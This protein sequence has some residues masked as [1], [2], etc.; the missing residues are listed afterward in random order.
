MAETFAPIMSVKGY[1][2]KYGV[3]AIGRKKESK[4]LV[5]AQILDDFKKEIFNQLAM[6]VGDAQML[7][8]D[9][10]EV[11]SE[12]KAKVDNI[13]NNSVRKWK[14][15]CILFSQYRETYNL[16]LPHELMVE[17][18][19][20]VKG[21]CEGEPIEEEQPDDNRVDGSENERCAD[22]DSDGSEDDKS[23]TD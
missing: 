10:S 21:I 7:A 8:K 17:L 4:E 13:I 23:D 22:G 9:I 15:L 6:H 12:T 3:E 14:R 18:E 11:D 5:K 16:I 1:F 20:V 19:D 2:N